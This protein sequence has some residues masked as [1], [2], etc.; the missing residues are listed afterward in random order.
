MPGNS[1]GLMRAKHD[2]PHQDTERGAED[3]AVR[4]GGLEL[5]LK[6][7]DGSV[8]T[9]AKVYAEHGLGEAQ[10]YAHVLF[11]AFLLARVISAMK[12]ATG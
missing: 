8:I 2:R 9:V 4:K 6:R 11:A 5:L 7:L 12:D 1:A 3:C 10:A